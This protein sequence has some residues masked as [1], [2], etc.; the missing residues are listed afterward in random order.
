MDRAVLPE[1]T[2]ALAELGLGGHV[3]LILAIATG[4]VVL[5]PT[6]PMAIAAGLTYGPF[7]APAALLGATLGS[8]AATLLARYLIRSRVAALASTRPKLQAILNAI[9]HEG[10]WV[11]CLL[12]FGS[13]APGPVLS[14]ALGLTNIRMLMLVSATLVG[15]AVPI[16][17]WVL[18]GAAGRGALSGSD[19][20]QVQLALLCAAAVTTIV[21]TVLVARRTRALLRAQNVASGEGR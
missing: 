20:P 11:V 5:A 15:K 18:V 7:G 21:A 13:P 4:V 17:V 8:T 12:R 3:L 10:W 1:L 9:E 6:T 16:T 19:I 2:G 14:Y